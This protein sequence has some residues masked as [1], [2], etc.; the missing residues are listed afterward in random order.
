MSTIHTGAE[1]MPNDL[2]YLGFFAC[3]IGR[4]IRIVTDVVT[5]ALSFEKAAVRDGRQPTRRRDTGNTGSGRVSSRE[6]V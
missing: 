1:L 6:S 3:Q 5:S 2:S 4:V